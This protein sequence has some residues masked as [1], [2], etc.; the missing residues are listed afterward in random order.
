MSRQASTF[1][2]IVFVLLVAIL[3]PSYLG[4]QWVKILT[5]AACF[6]IAAAGVSMLYA[7]L[8]MVSLAQ[9]GLMGVGGWVMLRMNHGFT[10]PFEANL[11]DGVRCPACPAGASDA[12]SLPCAGHIDGGKRPGGNLFDLPF[13]QRRPRLLG[14]PSLGGRAVPQA[15][16][17]PVG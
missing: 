9:V 7:R 6:A 12:R 1:L 11:L 2:G 13:S 17:C 14:R 3:G 5:S 4:G 16:S 10:L 8:N 15:L